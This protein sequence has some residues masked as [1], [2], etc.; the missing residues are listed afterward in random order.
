MGCEP[1]RLLFLRTGMAPKQV[2]EVVDHRLTV[3]GLEINLRHCRHSSCGIRLNM[4]TVPEHRNRVG[5]RLPENV[6]RREAQE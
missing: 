2:R 6:E 3:R 1:L 5:V 4:A